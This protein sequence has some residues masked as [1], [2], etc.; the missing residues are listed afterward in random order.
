MSLLTDAITGFNTKLD[1]TIT[2][3]NG[4]NATIPNYGL[5]N[6]LENH[7]NM[8]IEESRSF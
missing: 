8:L 1:N 5:L 2:S 7:S 6:L 4:V 3:I